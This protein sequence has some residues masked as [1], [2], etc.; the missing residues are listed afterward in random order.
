MARRARAKA[1]AEGTAN[2]SD[3]NVR[4]VVDDGALPVLLGLIDGAAR[5]VDVIAYS[6]PLTTKT[7]PAQNA[8]LQVAT[9][10]L[11]AR[12]RGARVRLYIEDERETA[13][14][15]RPTAQLLKDGGVEVVGG[16][17]HAKGVAVDGRFVLFGSTNLSHQSLTRNIETDL[18]FD[19]VD[20]AAGFGACF[21]YLWQGGGHGGFDAPAPWLADGAFEG[22]LVDVIDAAGE[23][24]DFS[25]Y[26]FD[27]PRIRDALVRAHRRGV[28][29][30]GLLHDHKSFALS[31][32]RRTMKTARSLRDAGV[33][34]LHTG[35]PTLFT[36]SKVLVRDRRELMLGTG[37]WL[38]EDVD[39]H[40]QL[41]VRL[42]DAAL[43]SSLVDHLDATIAARG[44]P[45]TGLTW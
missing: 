17:T 44:T 13:P 40:P 24:V 15:N 37:N 2:A 39:I 9:A 18:L 1:K 38:I 30:R 42:D 36:H 6:F 26:F 28:V 32:V 19:D 4:L 11:R 33:V 7:D 35:P 21:D 20:V 12:Q 8:P 34:D 31:Y 29:V 23:R 25:I 14:R 41:Y 43:A 5:S 22:A 10:L 3:A 16:A 45:V 27:H